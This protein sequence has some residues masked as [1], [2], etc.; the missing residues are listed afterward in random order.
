MSA[1]VGKIRLQGLVKI[2]PDGTWVADPDSPLYFLVRERK[3]AL[4]LYPQ[5]GTEPGKTRLVRIMQAQPLLDDGHPL[6]SSFR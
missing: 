6:R 5:F 1:C 4:P 3:V 2:V